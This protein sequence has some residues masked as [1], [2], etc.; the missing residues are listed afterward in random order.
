[1]RTK[2]PCYIPEVDADCPN[3]R[4]GCKSTCEE[5]K[6]WEIIH[7]AEVEQEQKKRAQERNLNSFEYEQPKRMEKARHREYMRERKRR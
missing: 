5:W 4:S 7:K 6:K 3:R 1:M 2:P